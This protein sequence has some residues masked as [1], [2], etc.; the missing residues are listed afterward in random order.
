MSPAIELCHQS[1]FHHISQPLPVF[2]IV[3]G[4]RCD[5]SNLCTKGSTECTNKQSK[6]VSTK[7]PQWNPNEN[8]RDDASICMMLDQIN[9]QSELEH[10]KLSERT[11]RWQNPNQQP[12]VV[13]LEGEKFDLSNLCVNNSKLT[14]ESSVEDIFRL[15]RMIHKGEIFCRR[16]IE[17]S[18]RPP[19]VFVDREKQRW[20]QQ[21]QGRVSNLYH[22]FCK[23]F[24]PDL[25]RH[26][27]I[28]EDDAQKMSRL[29]QMIRSSQF[30]NDRFN[31][32]SQQQ[33]PPVIVV[34]GKE[35]DLSNLCSSNHKS[36]LD[37]SE[38]IFCKHPIK[39]PH[40]EESRRRDELAFRHAGGKT[41]KEEEDDEEEVWQEINF[42]CLH[43]ISIMLPHAEVEGIVTDVCFSCLDRLVQGP[44]QTT[45][46]SWKR[47]FCMCKRHHGLPKRVQGE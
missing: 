39:S 23:V 30:H 10:R 8:T 11:E 1:R 20:R 26:S 42:P 7:H 5:L 4:T 33:G 21:Q 40:G 44:L 43:E 28:E 35:Y 27:S 3:D 12:P 24:Y 38:S 6:S 36:H 45:K 34:D 37:S 46:S 32:R 14:E 16:Q 13:V 25:V 31:E 15:E 22:G 9:W 29:H 17:R 2:V 18:Q 19:V 47:V 41:D